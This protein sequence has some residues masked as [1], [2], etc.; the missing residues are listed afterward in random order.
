[1][2]INYLLIALSFFAP[3]VRILFSVRDKKEI[4]ARVAISEWLAS[5][6]MACLLIIAPV[7][8]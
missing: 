4:N 3:I 6:I 1:M 5:G 8:D 7:W 2:N